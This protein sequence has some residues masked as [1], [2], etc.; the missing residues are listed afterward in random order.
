M[1]PSLAAAPAAP[2]LVLPT[3][4]LSRSAVAVAVAATSSFSTSAPANAK[5]AEPGFGKHVR[6][7]KKMRLSKFKKKKDH[8]RG[9]APLPG[10]RKAFRKRIQ[11]SNNNALEVPG[12]PELTP[13]AMADP[14]SVGQVLAIPTA[15]VDQLRQSEA[16]K[17]TQCWGMFRQPALLLRGEAVQLMQR[18]GA[19]AEKKEVLRMV[20]T[21]ERRSGKSTMLLSAMAHAYLNNWVVINIPEGQQQTH[22]QCPFFFLFFSRC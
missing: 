12:L 3:T 1:R 4:L 8:D 20:I 7:G 13:E 22:T 5:V 9:K 16:F 17:P 15:V 6:A 18:L 19:A 14:A 10:E 21:G 11:L 2:R